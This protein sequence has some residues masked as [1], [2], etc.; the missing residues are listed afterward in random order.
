MRL[1]RCGADAVLV[2]LDS[3]TAVAAARAALAAAELPGLV[4]LVPAAR[5]VLATFLP[6]SSGARLLRDVLEQADLATP[7]AVA[8]REVVLPAVY[9]GPDLDLVADTAGLSRAAAIALHA[10]ADYAVAFCGFAPGFAYLTGLPEP[11]CQPRLDTP[12]A[13]VPVGAIGVAGEFTGIYPRASPGGWRLVARLA[14]AAEALF[15]PAREP[16]A[17]L[18]PGDRVRF[19]VIS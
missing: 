9:D 5:T 7:P 15:D 19:E 14:D 6:G 18:A 17:L 8:S 10:G 1:R 16:A 4:D 13:R 2:E 11:L 12:R 3:L